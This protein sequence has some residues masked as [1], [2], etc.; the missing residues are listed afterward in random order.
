MTKP[1]QCNQDKD[2]ESRAQQVVEDLIKAQV[3][4][5]LGKPGAFRGV[6]VRPLWKN[7][8][9]V[10]LLVG[11]DVVSTRVAHSYFLVIDDDG[12]IV[13]STPEITKQH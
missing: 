13:A 3:I 7:H 10:N 4:H 12:L 1:P 9:R 11:E 6:Q 5:N 8:F 2:N